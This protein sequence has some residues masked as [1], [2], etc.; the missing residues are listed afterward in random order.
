MLDSQE[1]NNIQREVENLSKCSGDYVVQYYDSWI[2][3]NEWLCIEMELCSDNL[4]N[5]IEEK[6]KCFERQSS[7]AMNSIEFYISCQIFR[8]LLECVQYLHESNPQIIHR[9]LKPENILIKENQ[10]NRRFLKLG[11][12]GLSREHFH[13][14]DS[15]TM[16]VGTIKYMAR[17]VYSKNYSTKVDVYSLGQITNELF[18]LS[19]S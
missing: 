13:S 12:F 17:E 7:E 6:P 8:E 4:K 14:G 11:D 15:H 3:N 19:H 2:E 18:D 16:A 10:N 1:K 9:D 5:I